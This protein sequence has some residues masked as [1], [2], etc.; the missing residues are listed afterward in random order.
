MTALPRKSTSRRTGKRLAAALLTVLAVGLVACEKVPRIGLEVVA[1]AQAPIRL[2]RLSAVDPARALAVYG[3]ICRYLSTAAGHPVELVVS[4]NYES[5][6]YLLRAGLI[7]VAWLP[8]T[9]LSRSG[10]AALGVPLARVI[11]RGQTEYAGA[12]VTRASGPVKSLAELK[13]RRFAYVDRLSGSGFADANELLAQ[14]GVQPLADFTQIAFT[15]SHGE[16]LRGVLEGRYDAAAVLADR[17]DNGP[18]AAELRILARSR[19]IPTGMLVA[20]P[21]VPE[22]LREKLRSAL[23]G[24]AKS[25]DGQ[26]TLAGV[27]ALDPIDGFAAVDAAPGL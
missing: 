15:G 23:L 5:L 11:R 25:P 6:G 2:G 8:S 1:G 17:V 3:P 20:A 10:G 7:E 16:S 4:P 26:A 18:H 12:I 21:E 9:A 14:A 22:A 13:G 27:Q 19:A 24:M